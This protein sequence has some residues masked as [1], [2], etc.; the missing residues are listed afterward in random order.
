MTNTVDSSRWSNKYSVD[1]N[2]GGVKNTLL[3]GAIVP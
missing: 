1:S 2:Y 3:T